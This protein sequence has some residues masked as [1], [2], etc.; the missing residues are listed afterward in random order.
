[1]LRELVFAL[2]EWPHPR[3]IF[4]ARHDKDTIQPQDDVMR[5]LFNHKM[6]LWRQAAASGG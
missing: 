5:I 3:Y 1:M 2:Q 6:T 4:V